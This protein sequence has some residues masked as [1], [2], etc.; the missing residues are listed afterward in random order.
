[1]RGR[2]CANN[3]SH[4]AD[5]RHTARPNDPRYSCEGIDLRNE[6]Q[7]LLDQNGTCVTGTGAATTHIHSYSTHLFTREVQ[8]KLHAYRTG[9][10]PMFICACVLLRP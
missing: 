2:D 8:K 3:T 5:F 4:A 6:T 1:M 10:A 9:D 7:P